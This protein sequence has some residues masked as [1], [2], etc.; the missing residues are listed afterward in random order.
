MRKHEIIIFVLLITFGLILVGCGSEEK[1]SDKNDDNENNEDVSIIK[2]STVHPMDHPQTKAVID[3]T[4]KVTEE[5]GGSLEFDIYP[6]GELGD[7]ETVYDEITRGTIDMGLLTIP[8]GRNSNLEILGFPY[9]VDNYDQAYTLFSV[10]DGYVF[11]IVDEIIEDH[12][13]KLLGIRAMG[14]GG[15]G[16]TKELKNA[17]KPGEN[18]DVLV[19]IPQ[20]NSFQLYARD[21]GFNTNSLPFSEVFSSLQ[22]NVIDGTIGSPASSNYENFRDIITDYYQYNY[23]FEGTGFI[24]NSELFESLSEEEQKIMVDYGKEFTTEGI[25]EA[26]E[27]DQEY[28]DKLSEEGI[29]IHEFS[30]EE[31]REMADFVRTE[32]WPKIEEVDQGYLDEVREIIAD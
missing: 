13:A 10:D 28:R 20:M 29:T 15:I 6:A 23:G 21:F 25:A 1:K 19:R 31:I 2:V 24:V 30:E 32:T 12:G 18:K 5:T 16:T 4:E 11:E 17:N 3:Y 8:S 27:I 9:L 14:F 26:A 22:T 7:Y